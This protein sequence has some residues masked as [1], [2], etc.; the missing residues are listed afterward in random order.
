MIHHLA[1]LLSNSL[2]AMYPIMIKWYPHISTL[3]QTFLRI[4]VILCISFFFT[5]SHILQLSLLSPPFIAIGLVNLVHIYT[6]YAAYK[7]LNAGLA[8]G[9]FYT[10]PIFIVLLGWLLLDESISI[11]T[12]LGLFACFIGVLLIQIHK[13]EDGND[14]SGYM[15]ITL[16]ALTEAIIILFYK[17]HHMPNSFDRLFTLYALSLIPVTALMWWYG[18]T[19]PMTDAVKLS[20][21]H[22]LFG[23]G[24]YLLR[25]FAVDLPTQTFSLLSYSQIIIAFFYGWYLLGETATTMDFAGIAVLIGGILQMKI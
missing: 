3:S 8:T 23:F 5:S 19:I 14:R 16:A 13:M 6:S 10:Y 17:T 22:G 7:H 1:L 25:L 21:F 12:T 9:L 20:G 18:E 15:Y 24:G 2:L 4:L 11:R